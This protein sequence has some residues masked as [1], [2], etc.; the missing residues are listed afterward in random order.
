MGR[1]RCDLPA[2]LEAVRSTTS[3]ATESGYAGFF[4]STMSPDCDG[5]PTTK[6]DLFLFGGEAAATSQD[7]YGTSSSLFMTTM[8]RI[9]H[10]VKD[11]DGP[12]AVEYAVILMLIVVVC[13]T[14]IQLIGAA[15]DSSFQNSSDKIEQAIG[16]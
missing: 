5:R 6:Y 13:M 16:S 2:L 3:N 9:W 7:I 1:M 8:A 14:T 10:F 15:L 12:T 4:N 11:E